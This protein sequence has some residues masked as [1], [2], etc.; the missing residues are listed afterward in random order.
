MHPL[1][2]T[3]TATH[4]S[5]HSICPEIGRQSVQSV[6]GDEVDFIPSVSD[7]FRLLRSIS[8]RKTVR[9]TEPD[10]SWQVTFDTWGREHDEWIARDSQAGFGG[11]GTV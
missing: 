6:H 9:R 5:T 7:T 10:S 1:H 3:G 8:P 4:S 2:Q 11:F